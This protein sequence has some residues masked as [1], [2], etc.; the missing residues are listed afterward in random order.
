MLEIKPNSNKNAVSFFLAGTIE[1]ASSYDWQNDVVKK[2]SDTDC[3]IYNP[4]RSDWNNSWGEDSDELVD[5]IN[6]ELDHLD[7]CDYIL[8]YLDP[9]SKSPIS[10]LELGLYAR[11][12]KLVVACPKGFYRMTNIKTTCLKYNIPMYSTIDELVEFAKF[13]I[14]L[15]GK[16]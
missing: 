16:K 9:K 2:L 10:L 11:S 5:Q 4:R 13:S 6:W 7:K 14:D 8:M 1:M 15:L 3:V 12:G